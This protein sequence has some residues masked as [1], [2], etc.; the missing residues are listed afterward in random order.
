MRAAPEEAYEE[1]AN[2]IAVMEVNADA[3][4]KQ[5]KAGD[6]Q[7]E[8]ALRT[9]LVRAAAI[10]GR[11][12][13]D[14][15]HDERVA[16]AHLVAARERQKTWDQARRDNVHGACLKRAD[17]EL[18]ASSG[19]ERALFDRVADHRMQRMLSEP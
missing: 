11:T 5:V 12:Y 19:L 16:K 18:A 7:R 10:V 3:L 8:P 15:M 1:T 17:A 2:C 9:E 13:L 4:A 14:G 6:Q